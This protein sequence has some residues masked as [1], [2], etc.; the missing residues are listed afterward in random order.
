MGNTVSLDSP[1]TKEKK[2]SRSIFDMSHGKTAFLKESAFLTLLCGILLHFYPSL[3]I[4]GGTLALFQQIHF[5]TES[6]VYL[7]ILPAVGF[8]K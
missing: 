8:D 2:M 7:H 6:P 3:S 1:N 4:V 5:K